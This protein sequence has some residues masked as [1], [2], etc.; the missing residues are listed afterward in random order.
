MTDPKKADP[1]NTPVAR[2]GLR[3]LGVVLLLL[4]PIAIYFGT[5][6]YLEGRDSPNWP[7]VP[8]EVY[9]Q[10]V[11]ESNYRGRAVNHVYIKYRYNVNGRR[12]EGERVAP[13]MDSVATE[14]LAPLL[15]KYP[16]GSRPEVAYAPSNP[17]TAFLEPGQP[18]SAIW[19]AFLPWLF[20]VVGIALLIKSRRSRSSA[21]GAAEPV[22]A[23]DPRRQIGSR[24]S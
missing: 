19:R 21:T 6:R 1:F 9:D 14:D 10:K 4:S 20:P 8:G 22:V 24:E 15:A 11:Y 13:D 2:M 17:E 5:Q 7:R 23:P 16:V 12:Y 3:I 18:R